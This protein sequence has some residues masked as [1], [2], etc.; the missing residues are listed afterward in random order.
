MAHW[1]RKT[2][3]YVAFW[4]RSTEIRPG[5]DDV[6]PPMPPMPTPPPPPTP[7]TAAMPVLEAVYIT[8]TIPAKRRITRAE[9]AAASTL[10]YPTD[11]VRPRTRGACKGSERPCPFVSCKYHLYLDVNCA[12][13]LKLNF[14]GIELEDMAE[15]CALDVADRGGAT[16]EEIGDLLNVTREC[17]RQMELVSLR[18]LTGD[19]ADE[20][21]DEQASPLEQRH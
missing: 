18:S 8:K 3:E 1:T 20:S 19:M 14:P 11:V 4:N 12:G 9:I 21:E 6:S 7:P 16:L 15:T 2:R 17:V 5:V 10:T 13:G